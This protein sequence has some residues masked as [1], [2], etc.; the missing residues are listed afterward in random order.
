[1]QK[2]LRRHQLAAGVLTIGALVFVLW[3]SA[4][5]A[6]GPAV[7]TLLAATEELH[8]YR[9][10][11]HTHTL[12]SDGDDYPEMVALWY[13][14]HG[15]DFLVF[16]DHNTL[17]QHE[18]WITPAKRRAG[19]V[20]LDKLRARFPEGWIEERRSEDGKH[21][22]RL[23]TFDEL[24]ARFNKPGE[25][26]LVQGEE[27]TS[28]FGKAPVHMNATNLRDLIPPI[29]GESVYD[30]MQRTT[31][32]LVAQRERTGRPMLIHLNHPNFHYGITAEDLMRVRGENFFEVY[33]GHP[34]VYNKGDETH[35]STDRIWDIV[36]TNRLTELQLPLMYALATDDS[37]DYHSVRSRTA[38]PGRGWVQVLARELT[39]AALIE[40]MEAGRFYASCGVRLAKVLTTPRRMEIE[41][42]AEP[43]VEYTIEFIGT[44][45]GFDPTSHEVRNAE[46]EVLPVTRR[47]SDD[48]GRV[49]QGSTGTSAAYDLTD[50]DLYVRARVTSTRLHPN[51]SQIGDLERA[52][53]QP[54]RGPAAKA[55]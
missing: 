3:A 30:V 20:A 33:N 26:L 1:M 53:T 32:V 10:N 52:W 45:R 51:P 4:P 2:V 18:R 42:D 31:D 41:V 25:F 7:T 38:E 15:Y 23:K 48:V 46:G 55:E 17:Q 13:K 43:G 29:S 9:G 40:A 39:P 28:R 19:P 36:N 47:Y 24:T 22:I 6:T 16:T 49:L 14:E 44:R 27:M 37:H 11:I 34:T 12:W 5:F 8:W 54:L 21:E 35:A 50:D